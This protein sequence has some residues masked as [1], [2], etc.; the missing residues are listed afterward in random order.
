MKYSLQ[1]FY[2]NQHFSN[3]YIGSIKSFFRLLLKAS[4]EKLKTVMLNFSGKIGN[5]T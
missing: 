1:D 4:I 5:A 2:L 3:R